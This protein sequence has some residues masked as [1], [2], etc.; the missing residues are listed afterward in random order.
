MWYF[1]SS[2]DNK[3]EGSQ[4]QDG[5]RCESWEEEESRNSMMR[6]KKRREAKKKG[7]EFF[8]GDD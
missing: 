7:K 6:K 1:K 3:K 4:R 8:F 2:A 5:V